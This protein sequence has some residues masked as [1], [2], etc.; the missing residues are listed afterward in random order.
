M[1]K[2][3]FYYNNIGVHKY[4]SLYIEHL[5]TLNKPPFLQHYSNIINKIILTSVC[6]FCGYKEYI[7]KYKV[8]NQFDR[9]LHCCIS[10]GV[11]LETST[12]NLSHKNI[13][14]KINDKDITVNGIQKF[15]YLETFLETSKNNN[16]ILFKNESHFKLEQCVHTNFLTYI[17][18]CIVIDN[19]FIYL[20]TPLI[21]QYT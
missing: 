2:I 21:S 5:R 10:C 6:K 18:T 1:N 19:E 4:S 8:F 15:D 14:I 9:Y 11:Y 13:T 20:R 16:H 7:K 17:V 3:K 12:L